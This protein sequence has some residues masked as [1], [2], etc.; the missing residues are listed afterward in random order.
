[1]LTEGFGWF[2]RSDDLFFA[3][4]GLLVDFVGIVFFHQHARLRTAPEVGE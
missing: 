3:G 4:L 1:M 2:A